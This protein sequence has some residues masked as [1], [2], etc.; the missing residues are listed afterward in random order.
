MSN[1]STL[2]KALSIL[3]EHGVEIEKVPGWETR[4]GSRSLDLKPEAVVVH[5]TGDASTP[6]SLIRDGRSN[7]AG[8]LANFLVGQSGRV[9]LVA[10][11]YSNNAGYGG[12]ANFQKAK[13]GEATVEMTPPATDG[14]WSANSHAWAIEGD[15][16]GDWPTVVREHVIAICAALHIAHG[17]TGARVIAH[18]ELTR[19]KPG[20]P[21]DDMGGVRAAVLAKVAEWTAATEPDPTPDPEPPTEGTPTNFCATTYNCQDPRFGGNIR[22]DAKVLRK[23]H[24]SVYLLTECPEA[25]RDFIRSKMRGGADRWKVWTREAQ[26]ILFDSTKWDHDGSE[27]VVFGPTSYHGAV[28]AT[29]T[30][31]ST[32]QRVQFAALHLP[33]KV[34]A[35]EA[36]RKAA[37]DKLLANLDANVPT[38]IGGDFNTTAAPEW[39]A[40]S[41]FSASS[42]EATTDGGRELDYVAALGGQISKATTLD[43][44]PASDH[45]V[46]R[47]R[48]SIPA[49]VSTL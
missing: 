27:S 14:S 5:H 26:A 21:G 22:D 7:L 16:R 35:S 9:Y 3:A 47:A 44:G 10:A 18:K 28:I 40:S 30:R 48:V 6:L 33:P 12:Y 31:K 23:A 2:T 45:L 43:P 42:V 41:G 46:V 38:V 11:G 8:P 20:D 39:L 24:S 13:A 17:W 34:V 49:P 32:G 29:L 19:R 15:G 37:F 1:V 36:D 4:D 25:V